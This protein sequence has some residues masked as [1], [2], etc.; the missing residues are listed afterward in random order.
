MLVLLVLLGFLVLTG[1]RCNNMSASSKGSWDLWSS[2]DRK[3]WIRRARHVLFVKI[4]CLKCNRINLSTRCSL[5]D[6]LSTSDIE[7]ATVVIAEPSTLCI[8]NKWDTGIELGSK[9]P[10]CLLESTN[11]IITSILVPIPNFNFN[12][13]VQTTTGSNINLKW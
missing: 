3:E 12:F 8:V 11:V 9:F 10:Q 13:C 6:W 2:H 1:W 4:C 5:H 7:Y